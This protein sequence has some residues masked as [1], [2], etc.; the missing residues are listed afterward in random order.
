M[1]LKSR[2][3][4]LEKKLIKKTDDVLVLRIDNI[5]FLNGKEYTKKEFE[6]S[7]PSMNFDKTIEIM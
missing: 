5:F 3:I 6:L 1:S 2:M 4:K 7:Y